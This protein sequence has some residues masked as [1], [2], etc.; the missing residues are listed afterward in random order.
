MQNKEDFIVPNAIN[1]DIFKPKK[2]F[3]DLN[4]KQTLGLDDN[5]ILIISVGN[6][7][8][9][10]NQKAGIDMIDELKNIYDYNN[11][12]YLICGMGQ[13]TN[14]KKY[15]CKLGVDK[16]V[17]FLGLRD[18]IPDLLRNADIFINFSMWEGLPLAVIEAF[19]SGIPTILSPIHEHKVISKQIFKNFISSDF[20][21]KSFAM[22]VI[23]LNRQEKLSHHKIF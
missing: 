6:L 23:E 11:F 7:R 21:G 12:H 22:S 15:S 8:P 16:N 2:A 10:K 5:A 9:Q 18:D 20:N 4:L 17:H 13:E 19:V 3:K 1:F 14:L